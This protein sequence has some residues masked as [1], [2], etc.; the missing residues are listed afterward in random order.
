M[1]NCEPFAG[2]LQNRHKN[3][4]LFKC[5]LHVSSLRIGKTTYLIGMQ[6]DVTNGVDTVKSCAD[7]SDKQIAELKEVVDTIFADNVDAWVA[8][9]ATKFKAAK[10]GFFPPYTETHIMPRYDKFAYLEARDKFVS[11]D[12]T[13]R[14]PGVGVAG[15]VCEDLFVGNCSDIGPMSSDIRRVSSEPALG[16]RAAADAEIS[17]VPTSALRESLEHVRPH[18]CNL[19]GRVMYGNEPT[20]AEEELLS[21][22]SASHPTDCKPC[23]FH[24]YSQMGC[25]KGRSCQFCHMQHPQRKRR[26]VRQKK[27][28][29]EAEV[30]VE[31]YGSSDSSDHSHSQPTPTPLDLMPLLHALER[32]APLPLITDVASSNQDAAALTGLAGF[33]ARKS[34]SSSGLA[35]QVAFPDHLWTGSFGNVTDS[36]QIQVMDTFRMSPAADLCRSQKN[37]YN[38]FT[39]PMPSPM[40]APVWP[41]LSLKY[42]E[43]KIVICTSQWKLVLPFVSEPLGM[44]SFDVHP[45][46]MQGLTLNRNTGVISGIPCLCTGSQ[47]M[48]HTVT[49]STHSGICTDAIVHITVLDWRMFA[50][51]S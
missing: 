47:G 13:V 46:L 37:A 23:S 27:N 33:S 32:L 38:I 9:Q 24:C 25:N 21:Q 49:V 26:H 10:F 5:L 48:F 41:K 15:S 29:R 39:A 51:A 40:P 42:N 36:G 8:L 7:A 1:R 19:Q 11:L 2:V 20:D 43:D 50:E 17:N 16:L 22:G 6:S 18:G 44:L 3:G 34:S 14:H 12:F 4:K 45:P 31:S 35:S 28:Q 30:R